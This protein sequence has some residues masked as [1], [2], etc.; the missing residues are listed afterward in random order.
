VFRIICVALGHSY[1]IYTFCLGGM[2]V[3]VVRWTPL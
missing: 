3:H 1:Y 2:A